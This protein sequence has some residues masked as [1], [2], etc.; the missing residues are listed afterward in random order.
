[1]AQANTFTTPKG[2]AQYPWLSKPDTKFS[3]E[4]DYKV[5][6]ILSAE[7]AAPI[8]EQ[9]NA[10]FADNMQA[11]MKKQGKKELK[12]ANPPYMEELGDDGQ[13]T[14]NVIFKFKSKAAYKPAIFDA[15]GK[16]MID[17][18]IWGGSE[19]RVNGT[20]GG[21]YTSL[22]GVGVA[23]RLRAVQV[24]QYV[25][26]SG[27]GATRFGFEE[28]AGYEHNTPDSF[29]EGTPAV[30]VAKPELSVVKEPVEEPAVVKSSAT[31]KAK[32]ISDIVSKWGAKD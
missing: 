26:G 11:E 4:G 29:Q 17:S 6:L 27:D 24:I 23:L 21:Y 16:P 10:A 31:D 25:E 28:T 9:I 13:P 8:V 15:K 30:K 3:E 18:N 20:I 1:M 32:D 14:G 7:E 2:I 19:I 5:N 12:A 22:I